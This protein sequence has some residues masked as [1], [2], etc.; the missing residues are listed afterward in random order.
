[1]PTAAPTSA[2]TH[3]PTVSGID[4]STTTLAVT[5]AGG[6]GHSATFTIALFSD[7]SANVVVTL[8]FD[9]AQLAV[10]PSTLTFTTSD[11]SAEQTVTVTAINDDLDED[12]SH[13][14]NIVYTIVST[15]TNY[16][17]L[18]STY[19][20]EGAAAV[21]VDITD[22]DTAGVTVSTT[23]LAL[24]EGSSTTAAYTAV[25]DSEPRQ[26]VRVSVAASAGIC[27][28]TAA[29]AIASATAVCN[30]D[31]DCASGS[32]CLTGTSVT[33]SAAYLDFTSANWDA[34]QTITVTVI[35][36][37]VRESSSA[38]NGASVHTA[39]I[40]HTC[41]SID[42]HYASPAT[43]GTDTVTVSITDNDEPTVFAT[44]SDIVSST[45]VAGATAT[46]TF[47]LVCTRGLA[48]AAEIHVWLPSAHVAVGQASDLTVAAVSGFDGTLAVGSLAGS[49]YNVAIVRAGGAGNLA[50][51][52]T[53][54]FTLAGVTN[55]QRAGAAGAFPRVATTLADPGHN[56]YGYTA[57]ATLAA[58]IDPAAFASQPT[59]TLSGFIAGDIVTGAVAFTTTNP[60][61]ADGGIFLTLPSAF[62][63][64]A[65]SPTISAT[66][67]IDGTLTAS[68]SGL[69][70]TITRSGG[71]IVTEGTA[72]GF[73]ISGIE[74]TQ[75]A[76]TTS[77]YPTLRTLWSGGLAA[78]DEAS[79]AFYSSDRIATVTTTYGYFGSPAPA[80][81]PNTLVAGDVGSAVLTFTLK[82]PL[83]KNG[84]IALRLPTTFGLSTVTGVTAGSGVDGTFAV[85]HTSHGHD[86]ITTR[87][88]DG[89]TVSSGTAITVTLAG[90]ANPI[91]SGAT[92]AVLLLRTELND[93]T[94]IDEASNDGTYASMVPP[95]LTFT[96]GSFT[97]APTVV[98]TSDRAGDV[99]NLTVTFTA[100]NSFPNDGVIIL[101]LPTK[102]LIEDSNLGVYT[103]GC[104]ETL[105]GTYEVG[106]RGCQSTTISGKECQAWA[107]QTPHTHTHTIANYPNGDVTSNLCR[108][109]DDWNSGIWCFTTD[110]HTRSEAC[111]P[112]PSSGLDGTYDITA[113]GSSGDYSRTVTIVRQGDGTPT[114]AGQVL[115]VTLRGIR[116]QRYSGVTGN[117][118]F[119]RTTKTDGTVIDEA[120][121]SYFPS[122]RAVLATDVMQP[123][124]LVDPTVHFESR[125]SRAQVNGFVLR[126]V[127]TNPIPVGG[128]VIL[129]L[130]PAFD[131]DESTVAV[132]PQA[133]G[134][135]PATMQVA[136]ASTNGFGGTTVVVTL[137]SSDSGAIDAISPGETVALAFT[138][139]IFLA[140][141]VEMSE[142]F[143]VTTTLADGE[144]IVD[145][146][147][148]TPGWA[149]RHIIEQ[150]SI[151][152]TIVGVE[153]YIHFSGRNISSLSNDSVAWVPHGASSDSD[154]NMENFIMYPVPVSDSKSALIKFPHGTHCPTEA[155][156][157]HLCYRFGSA[158]PWKLYQGFE[159]LV[160]DVLTMNVASSFIGANN[161][162]VAG[163][164]K[165][166]EYTGVGLADGD[167]LRYISAATVA[168]AATPG[169]S[170]CDDA[171]AG[172]V[173][174]AAEATVG[175][176]KG[177]LAWKDLAGGADAYRL[178]YEF[179]FEPNNTK[180]KLLS[181]AFSMQ[182]HEL[183]PGFAGASF[184]SVQGQPRP[185]LPLN[186][187]GAVDTDH[188]K[189]ITSSP[190]DV[191]N[192]A[193]CGTGVANAADVRG[194]DEVNVASGVMY[195]SVPLDATPLTAHNVTFHTVDPEGLHLCYKFAGEAYKLY[196]NITMLVLSVSSVAASVVGADGIIVAGQ[197][198]SFTFTGPGIGAHVS[199]KDSARWVP[200]PYGASVATAP[201]HANATAASFCGDA[202]APW[203]S[204]AQ[205]NIL[206]S[207]ASEDD[208]TIPDNGTYAL[209]Y[210][211]AAYRAD[212]ARSG[213]DIGAKWASQIFPARVMQ[214]HEV[215]KL[216]GRDF[217]EGNVAVVDY[218]KAFTVE[219]FGVAAG[220]EARWVNATVLTDAGCN[221]AISASGERNLFSASQN[222]VE[223]TSYENQVN[224]FEAGNV[225][226]G[227][228]IENV[229]F[230][231][232]SVD[233]LPWVLCYRFGLERWRA[234]PAVAMIA[235]RVDL[236]NGT[237]E[238]GIPVN[239]SSQIKPVGSN[240]RVGDRMKWVLESSETDAAC[241]DYV[242]SLGLP[243]SSVPGTVSGGT[244]GLGGVVN[245][246]SLD[247][248]ASVAFTLASPVGEPWKL[249]YAF[250]S[251]PF[252]LYANH[253]LDARAVLSM[254]A[255]APA[256]SAFNV[257]VVGRLKTFGL[258][259]SGLQTT[260][261]NDRRDKV[262]W[263]PYSTFHTLFTQRK[264][265]AAEMAASNSLHMTEGAYIYL[266][267][268]CDELDGK[269]GAITLNGGDQT[270][271]TDADYSTNVF[272]SAIDTSAAAF[273]LT[274]VVA[275]PR[276]EPYVMCYRMRGAASAMFVPHVQLYA[277]SL[278]P[279]ALSVASAV[280][281]QL[282]HATLSL[283]GNGSWVGDRVRFASSTAASDVDCQNSEP[284][285]YLLSSA[286]EW[287]ADGGTDLDQT[288]TGP[289]VPLTLTFAA[290]LANV[291]KLC[292][293]FGSEPYALFATSTVEVKGIVSTNHTIAVV[294][295]TL[296]GRFSGFGMRDSVDTAMW[297]DNSVATHAQCGSTTPFGNSGAG[298]IST[299]DPTTTT[300][301]TESIGS[302]KQA[303]WTQ[304]R[305]DTAAAAP[306]RLCYRFKGEEW[307]LYSNLEMHSLA[308]S[309]KSLSPGRLVV[310]LAETLVFTGD[311]IGATRSHRFKFIANDAISCTT[312]AEGG[313]GVVE[314]ND[315]NFGVN[316]TLSAAGLSAVVTTMVPSASVFKPWR[317]CFA[318]GDGPFGLVLNDVDIASVEL[319]KIVDA[320]ETCETQIGVA[321]PFKFEGTG[322]ADGDAVK[323][324]SNV[325][326][327]DAQCAG[328][329]AVGGAQLVVNEGASFTFT[330][331]ASKL[332]LCYRFGAV[333]SPYRLY[334][335]L[336]MRCTPS[337]LAAA[338]ATEVEAEEN[339]ETSVEMR[340]AGDFATIENKTKFG[341]DFAAGVAAALGVPVSRI[342]VQAV[343]S[344]S[345]IVNF[346]IAPPPLAGDGSTASASA[347][348]PSVAELVAELTLQ[349]SSNTS[350]LNAPGALPASIDT[351]YTGGALGV[352]MPKAEEESTISLVVT[353][354]QS[355]GLF[356]FSSGSASVTEDG[357]AVVLNVTRGH[358]TAGRVYVAWS[359]TAGT[360]RRNVDFTCDDN[361]GYLWFSDGQQ[362]ALLSIPIIDDSVY[363]AHYESFSV[364]LS[365]LPGQPNIA[366]GSLKTTTVLI[367]DYGDGVSVA[368][369]APATWG[370]RSGV[371]AA[372]TLLDW[373]L[374]GNGDA[375]ADAVPAVD[376]HGMYGTDA[377]YG[378]SEYNAACDAASDV[379][380]T[381]SCTFG[382]AYAP[383][384]A[385]GPGVA[386]LDGA[387]LSAI[388][389]PDF[390]D[391]PTD[392]LTVSL[393]VRAAPATTGTV[394]SFAA[395]API[396][397]FALHMH[398]GRLCVLVH[399]RL[400][401]V[402]RGLR[403]GITVA[404]GTL[405]HISASWRSA[406]GAVQVWI[407]GRL[408]WTGPGPYRAGRVLSRT[409]TLVIGQLA[410]GACGADASAA[411][412]CAFDGTR[413]W[414]GDVQNVR[415][416]SLVLP[417][418]R[419]AA[420][421]RWPFVGSMTGLLLN[422]RVE[423]ALSTAVEDAQPALV[424]SSPIG[425]HTGVVSS[426]GVALVT[427]TPSL[428][429]AY[430][431]PG[432]DQ[433]IYK[434]I[435][436]F[437]APPSFT[438]FGDLSALTTGAGGR[439]Q[440]R[441]MT[442]SHSGRVRSR[443]GDVVIKGTGVAGTS[444]T[445]SRSLDGFP[446]PTAGSGWHSYSV[447]MRPRG[448]RTEPSGEDVDTATFEAVLGSVS[449]LLI[450]G[451]IWVYASTGAGQETV[452]LN[453]VTLT[454]SPA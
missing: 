29:H 171:A 331:E 297:V 177:S 286:P 337:A 404:D 388:V 334:K 272:T 372:S 137:T 446:L 267:L 369:V 380:C 435:W 341:E 411:G 125:V 75:Y 58:V 271:L 214:S 23:A 210:A 409:G 232:P 37:F 311:T 324:V 173:T 420:D 310:G 163:A 66:S 25:L 373:S 9:A 425:N 397:E 241:G 422:W 254:R 162:A 451:D 100:T 146:A 287:E 97:G 160:R 60:I 151:N 364:T 74:L 143:R 191:I 367:Y 332:Q 298:L 32:E 215:Y 34:P 16:D 264:T 200:M 350:K 261:A 412:T 153:K 353:Q 190:G 121:S 426:T 223:R 41:A 113:S 193:S 15:D 167:V 431:C 224:V 289:A 238:D 291:L 21:T 377:S 87:Q 199:T 111:D 265:R 136:L 57:A 307:T 1:M 203:A 189:W 268:L 201:G 18:S 59:L 157:Y 428:N 325:V 159:L 99:V 197:P 144:T 338:V 403:T 42:A 349:V 122:N 95:A 329:D 253:R 439:L 389:L 441:L 39:S 212:D 64:L 304:W 102:Y 432:G 127:A 445:L 61:P 320:S 185:A 27:A 120:S 209:C 243:V 383:A 49:G 89:S 417:A 14:V 71:S 186:G 176:S 423:S 114:K 248:G 117:F 244:G 386:K 415:V 220:D 407:D 152:S 352:F 118:D 93:G 306:L 90:V 4:I 2:P 247:S 119:M 145:V 284:S 67:N 392:A 308:P 222:H 116:N 108:N 130:P 94:V 158:N 360:A 24:T 30:V 128:S 112:V 36:D 134:D 302:G 76:T 406:D 161:T 221:H 280:A 69:T 276:D 371:G 109:P 266:D 246:A 183:V 196:G 281:L 80:L 231:T 305:F 250:G 339:A 318:F 443:R 164:R 47:T 398:Q 263:I 204:S 299:Y 135:S 182:V 53:V 413:S 260:G 205:V 368:G 251:E 270:A 236:V 85:T 155:L 394:L 430:P 379:P 378:R 179:S 274:T 434:N 288:S 340:M 453:N 317:L 290:P 165:E 187:F 149:V 315:P 257:A 147:L 79:A 355:S 65:S 275:S 208:F 385:A 123:G 13:M 138:G 5:E 62:T 258:Y 365:V 188:V 303:G 300:A 229:N 375:G 219:G 46:L 213:V 91:W 382:G 293:R 363:E 234:Y 440:F 88:G 269:E 279:A 98:A 174:V 402:R 400:V 256:G 436:H 54:V 77:V 294:G 211:F 181:H 19:F 345:I 63:S 225:S 374:V 449:D 184:S 7:V 427:G 410:L 141:A 273:S 335:S 206:S 175:S 96:P 170:V 192:D 73:T 405:R 3:S 150:T 401:G 255:L 314:V 6:A 55:P 35:D 230:K 358:G 148:A 285:A 81:T 408:A 126:F 11:W 327:T 328:A 395:A 262:A 357:G 366:V 131:I 444:I 370:V 31:G 347:A 351:S 227:L 8:A 259:G 278:L 169:N 242:N 333:G 312:A 414:A 433:R 429:T 319:T 140:E 438:N 110:P 387:A 348:L 376:S 321:S 82:N 384:A 44:V 56:L 178:C 22:D 216:H 301:M 115:S 326:A 83:P 437:A 344:G 38:F 316:A 103:T 346:I 84:R 166:F 226:T 330:G 396:Q 313:I 12:A 92:G 442:P 107:V 239:V 132:M 133:A 139:T 419:R 207:G 217:G 361:G 156:T 450:R 48:A 70:V 124:D 129:T 381:H 296:Y 43:P 252:K 198:K 249:C 20:N 202:V 421:V 240:V 323:F 393:W 195:N 391:F 10:S 343:M 448:W 172:A 447:I 245:V 105:T 50:S 104:N 416:W 101:D 424:D 454:T 194:T 452:Y 309:I 233:G 33:L 86:I 292:V 106:Y 342:V 235:S 68:S 277:R 40:T 78:V 283:S 154:C 399:D 362:S 418:A 72:V 359:C 354:H 26:D 218:P 228:V 45:Y 180:H 168:A 282:K 237:Q 322:V 142:T 356:A 295:S 390:G 52:T 336:P 51:G 28:T 17:G